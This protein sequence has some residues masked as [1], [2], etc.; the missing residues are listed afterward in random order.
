MAVS[1]LVLGIGIYAVYA[2]GVLPG[3]SGSATA[4]TTIGLVWDDLEEDGVFHAY[5]GADDIEGL[6]DVDALPAGST[7]HVN[8]TAIDGGKDRSVAEAA[9]PKGYP[10][11]TTDAD[12]REL[13]RDI[14]DEGPPSDASVATRS[15]PV[16]VDS[17]AD[18]R[19]GT[20]RVA[21]W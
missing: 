15:I 20:L 17:E 1:M 3:A 21:V 2:Q 9:F 10:D 6:V 19:S 5:G 11:E 4:D 13:D 14:E 16:A 18:V 12:L 7:V 8:V